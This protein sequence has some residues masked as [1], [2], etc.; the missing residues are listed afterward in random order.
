[1]LFMSQSSTDLSDFEKIKSRLKQLQNK[2]GKESFKK[3]L[4]ILREYIESDQSLKEIRSLQCGLSFYD[5]Y[6]CINIEN[7]KR[8]IGK[9]KS[10][11]NN[12]IQQLGYNS[13][14]SKSNANMFL[15]E[16]L[17][18]LKTSGNVR[19]WSVRTRFIKPNTNDHLNNSK[20]SMV[21]PAN[22]PDKCLSISL[23][24]FNN[25]QDNSQKLD[26]HHNHS[27]NIFLHE[28]NYDINDCDLSY[29]YDNVNDNG[30]C[31]MKLE[32]VD[33]HVFPQLFDEI[34]SCF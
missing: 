7:L 9:C 31:N 15:Y 11:I 20:N 1:M 5:Q 16:A 24:F 18:S 33:Q 32:S 8:T 14:K 3:Q 4:Q 10:T 23:D 22:K 6:L 17:P 30:F 27:L 2:E 21:M 34:Y 28:P 19:K 13:I 12:C 26:K 25:H 29:M